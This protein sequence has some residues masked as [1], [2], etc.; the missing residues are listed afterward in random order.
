M[1][2]VHYCDLHAYSVSTSTS[3]SAQQSQ[4]IIKRV[5]N[6]EIRRT[7]DSFVLM[8]NKFL[9]EDMTHYVFRSMMH[10][11]NKIKCT[12]QV[13]GKIREGFQDMTA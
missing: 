12:P 9:S 3:S 7:I 4:V 6:M 11:A 2:Q 13:H 10:W 1:F 5:Y 8:Q